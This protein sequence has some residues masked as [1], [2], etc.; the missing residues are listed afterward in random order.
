[1]KR[2][3]VVYAL[4]RNQNDEVLIVENENSRWSLP[5]GAVEEDETLEQALIREVYEET[6]LHV[7]RKGLAL[8][9]ETKFQES[10]HHCVFFTFHVDVV[11]GTIE[12]LYPEEIT[13]IEWV[14][15]EI[16]NERM[17]YL[18]SG[19]EPLFDQHVTYTYQ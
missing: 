6:A 12:R 18:A 4:I 14:S 5:G 7:E 3:D 8:V 17:P 10:G 11:G 15:C 2:L 19:I 13:K 16:A 1:M 9:N